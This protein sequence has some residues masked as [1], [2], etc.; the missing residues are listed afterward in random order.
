MKTISFYH[1]LLSIH[2]IIKVLYQ[3]DI[4]NIHLMNLVK[5]LK[6]QRVYVTEVLQFVIR[7]IQMYLLHDLF[8]LVRVQYRIT[9]QVKLDYWLLTFKEKHSYLIKN[10]NIKHTSFITGLRLSITTILISNFLYSKSS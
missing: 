6:E 3:Y 5:E 10:K 4:Q 7:S 1:H 8:F 2:K 9:K